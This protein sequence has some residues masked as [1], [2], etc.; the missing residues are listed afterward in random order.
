MQKRIEPVEIPANIDYNAQHP[1]WLY[2][3]VELPFTENYFSKRLNADF[4]Y[5]LFGIV[6]AVPPTAR[7]G[8]IH[9]P[10]FLQLRHYVRGRFLFEEPITPELFST[11]AE[12]GYDAQQR[13]MIY[14]HKIDYLFYA[15]EPLQI[16]IV[17][18]VPV[19]PPWIDLL[20]IGKNLKRNLRQ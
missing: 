11:P 6:C 18:T 7:H 4:D 15:N 3:R 19:L 10:V 12:L 16:R 8:D 14:Y 20:C 5:M 2:Q 1:K 17:P 13:P 9:P